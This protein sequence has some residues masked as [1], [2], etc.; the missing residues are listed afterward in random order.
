MQL[1]SS[2]IFGLRLITFGSGQ[3]ITPAYPD[4]L[5]LR[6]KVTK[7]DVLSIFEYILLLLSL[8]PE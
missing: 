3:F 7:G 2:I 1:L 4:S 8:S 5:K 6:I